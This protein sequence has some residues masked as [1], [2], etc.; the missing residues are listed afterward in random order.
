[1]NPLKMILI[2]AHRVEQ[3][4]DAARFR[5]KRRLG[6]LGPVQ[7]MPFL[8]YGN[9][10]TVTVCGRVLEEKDLGDPQVEAPWWE[11]LRAMY[12]RIESD[13]IP[14][15]RLKAEFNGESR[16]VRTDD[17]GYFAFELTPAV[18]PVNTSGWFDVHVQLAEQ[19]NPSQGSVTALGQ[20]LIPPVN[21]DFAVISDIDDTIIR[22][23]ATDFFRMM[24]VL[25]LNN[26]RTRVPFEGVSAFYSALQK[27]PDGV[28]D[29]PIFYVSSSSWNIYDLLL[30][31]LDVHDIPRG[32]LL[33]RDLGLDQTKFVKS[34]HQHKLDKIER[35]FRFYP[36]TRFILIG[37][38]GQQ[39]PALYY[40][41]IQRHP[42]RVIAA[43]IRD[44]HP[45]NRPKVSRIAREVEALG[46]EMLLV[47]DT[48]E[49]AQHAAQRGLIRW[50]EVP[51]VHR[52]KKVDIE[53]PA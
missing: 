40:Q 15:V 7:I 38:S 10:S 21:A 11:N 17:E 33:L 6:W 29:N 3:H 39:D 45:L 18:L 30:A 31:F 5:L 24:R 13:E 1:M 32:P 23:Y 52:Q 26:A 8:G 19:V 36:Y 14:Y 28:S 35:I 44:V 43:Y 22:T 37:D 16:E 20:V 4:L 2:G 34:G 46:T 27:G 41:A 51:T 9:A 42:G 53:M 48:E 50:T 47:Q 12:H 49:A 25:F